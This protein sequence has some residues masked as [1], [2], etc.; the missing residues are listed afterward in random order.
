MKSR[1]VFTLIMSLILAALLTSCSGS[2]TA[3]SWPGYS[4]F[5]DKIFL[6]YQ[7]GVFAI[8]LNNGNLVWQYPEKAE[9]RRNY[10]ASP[11]VADGQVI[12]G[13]YLNTLHS[14]NL[15]NGTEKWIYDTVNG[16]FISGVAVV[17]DTILAS[18]SDNYLYAFDLSGDVRWK[19]QTKAANWAKP[20]SDGVAAYLPSMDHHLYAVD[21]KSGAELWQTDLGGAVVGGLELNGERLYV[22]TLSNELL[23]VDKKDGKVVWRFAA[24]GAVWAIPILKEGVL[25]FADTASTIYA[26]DAEA[27]TV[28]WRISEVGGPIVGSAGMMEKGLVFPTEDGKLVAVDFNGQRLWEKQINGKL[29]SSPVVAEGRIITGVNDGDAVLKAFDFNGS[30]LWSFALPK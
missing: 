1:I 28:R 8:N 16:R 15:E 12:V 2:M 11:Q 6:S 22:G 21:L 23:A 3:T 27:G 19:F 7:T 26:L 30:E 24:D 20:A 10:Y 17:K 18:A 5:E 25:Y 14:L 13:D 29:Y 9:S 4:V